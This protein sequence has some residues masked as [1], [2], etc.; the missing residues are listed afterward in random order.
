[1]NFHATVLNPIPTNIEDA[2]EIKVQA[3][4]EWGILLPLS[5][6]SVQVVCTLSIG[7]VMS[8][9]PRLKLKHALYSIKTKHPKNN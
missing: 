4:G 2:T 1:M 5:D 3:K 8:E 6:G 7:Q 9:M